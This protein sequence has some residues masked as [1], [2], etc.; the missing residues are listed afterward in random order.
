[1][2]QVLYCPYRLIDKLWYECYSMIGLMQINHEYIPRYCFLIYE[3]KFDLT[4]TNFV[5]IIGTNL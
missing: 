4:S 1:M 3:L 5:L 2:H